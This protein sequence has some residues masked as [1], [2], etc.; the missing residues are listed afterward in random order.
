MIKEEKKISSYIRKFRMEQFAK[1][2]MTNG[3]LKYDEIFLRIFSYIRKPFLIHDFIIAPRLI[4]FYMR[5]ILFYFFIIVTSCQLIAILSILV[6]WLLL[7][8]LLMLKFLL[9]LSSQWSLH[10]SGVPAVAGTS[11]LPFVPSVSGVPFLWC[12]WFSGILLLLVCC[13]SFILMHG[14]HSA[15]DIPVVS[16]I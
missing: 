10:F 8:M 14:N 9:P 2:Y 4:F 15:E 7:L 6:S 11:A 5:K 12:P 1:S 16:S 3:L 13:Y